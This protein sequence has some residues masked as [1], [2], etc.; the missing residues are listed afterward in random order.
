MIYYKQEWLQHLKDAIPPEAKRNQTSLYTIALEGWRRGLTLKFYLDDQQKGIRYSLSDE[1]KTHHFNGSSGD[2]NTKEA[3]DICENKALTTVYLEANNI[4]V[5]RG[6][7]FNEKNKEKEIVTYAKQLGYPLVVKPTDG[8]GGASVFANIKN[9]QGLIK[10]IKYI[11]EKQQ[12]KEIIVQEHVTGDEVRVYVLNRKVLAAA[13][14]LPANV[15]GDGYQTIAQL[16]R[17]KNELRKNVPHLF[18]RPIKMDLQVRQ[19]IEQENYTLES[20][21][22]KDK[23]VYLSK[24]SNVSTG[25]DPIDITNELTEDQRDIAVGASKAIPGLTHSGV[26][27]IINKETGKTVVL[28]VNTRPGIGSHLFPIEGEA[29]D[30]PKAI[31][32][33]YFPKTKNI[34]IAKEYFNLQLVLDSLK[35]GVL[36]EIVMT[37]PSTFDLSAK[38]YIIK[39]EM[40]LMDFYS[41]IRKFI[42]SNRVHGFIK[43]NNNE[44]ELEIVVA[45]KNDEKVNEF[46]TFLEQRKS[47]LQIKDIQ[48]KSYNSPIKM[49]F[50]I[51]AGLYTMSTLELEIKYN[52]LNKE[53]KVTEKEVIRLN[54]R[55]SLMKNSRAWKITAPLRKL[56]DLLKKK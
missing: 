1:N 23:R 37:D 13:N 40:N 38:R 29:I 50:S 39:S 6:S 48:E 10:A 9:E 8:S 34:K 49:G 11:K 3:F 7:T 19:L 22:P 5:P 53:K 24:T 52:R 31:I 44:T 33:L 27:I 36:D 26:D 47:L 15:V 42:I 28:E 55:I 20:V 25:G 30:I 14:R 2:F 21:L 45:H 12:Y 46:R 4:P 18:H 41:S 56:T 54:R 16:I 17:E 32:D 43:R 51:I 35:D